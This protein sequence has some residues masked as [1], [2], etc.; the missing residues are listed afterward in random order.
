MQVW[1]FNQIQNL[2]SGMNL[3]VDTSNLNEIVKFATSLSS[4]MAVEE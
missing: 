3:V 4:I 2:I 1:K